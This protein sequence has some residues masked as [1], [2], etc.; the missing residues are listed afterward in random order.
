MD[1]LALENEVKELIDLGT[2][3]EYWDF[4]QEWHSTKVDLLHD[5]ICMANNLASKDA[6]IIIGVT[7]SKSDG[8]LQVVGVP[9]TNR[10][11]QQELIDFI[12]GQKFA[13]DIRPIVYVQTIEI[14]SKELDVIIIKNTTNTPYFLR[15]PEHSGTEHV[16]AANIYTRIGDTNTPKNSSADIDK[17]E[18]LW[19]KRFGI[20][21][22]IRERLSLLLDEPANWE[23]DIENSDT[24]YHSIF[25]E[26]KIHIEDDEFEENSIMENIADKFSKNQYQIS[27]LE[28]TYHSTVIHQER[29]ILLDGARHLIPLPSTKTIYASKYSE[30]EK[31][32][33]Y[34]YFDYS[35]IQGKLFRCLAQG[36]DNWYGE[37]WNRTVGCSFL[38]FDNNEDRLEFDK[39]VKE[40]LPEL[41]STYPE[42]L[43]AKGYKRNSETE[44]YYQFGW[45]K[46]NEIKAHYLYD[47]YLGDTQKKITDYIYYL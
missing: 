7:D 47:K 39:L 3:G 6:Y 10:K 5:I 22:T 30:L 32:L 27:S 26:F 40:N 17:I 23:G 8:G 28:I 29:L 44:D 41:L 31:S 33:T 16:Y 15:E 21:R 19:R 14:Y 2:E 11:T 43:K 34:L 38:V 18:M 13:G 45:S 25:P 24:K 9:S 1:R 42:A 4:K 20:D 12:K 35:T 37:P 46:G 36:K